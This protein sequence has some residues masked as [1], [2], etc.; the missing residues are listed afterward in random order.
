[1]TST[2]IISLINPW[3]DPCHNVK[4]SIPQQY[5]HSGEEMDLHDAQMAGILD[6]LL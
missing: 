2:S 5:L 6:D 3:D 1:M 4:T